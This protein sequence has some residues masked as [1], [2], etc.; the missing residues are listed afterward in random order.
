ME[1]ASK[2]YRYI[3]YMNVRS[4]YMFYMSTQYVLHTL[5][6]L[7]F[8]FRFA[9]N[10]T[11]IKYENCNYEYRYVSFHILQEYI[12]TRYSY[13]WGYLE[14]NSGDTVTDDYLV[15]N[16][17]SSSKPSN[18]GV[19]C[20]IVYKYTRSS[21]CKQNTLKIIFMFNLHRNTAFH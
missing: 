20:T 1:L 17:S 15:I 5:E 8:R 11:W 16:G 4:I 7:L 13:S 6:Q 10:W 19:I 9:R 3:V 18:A 2:L 12:V 14:K 21:H